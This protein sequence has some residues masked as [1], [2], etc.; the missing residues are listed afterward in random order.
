[1]KV[2]SFGE[3]LWD[4]IGE[5]A[6]LGGAPL[7]FAA[8]S[9]LC[10][11]RSSMLSRLGNDDFGK[12]AGNQIE[13]L[14][15]GTNLLQI[16]QG[17]PTG[18]VPVKLVDGQPDYYITSNAAYDFIDF[19]EAKA[20]LDHEKFEVLYFGTL[21]QRAK[22]GKALKQILSH[23]DFQLKFYDINLRKDCYSE[24]VIRFSLGQAD[25]VKLNEEEVVQIGQMLFGKAL[26]PDNFVPELRM[27]FPQID[28]VILTAGGDGC[29]VF[30]DNTLHHIKSEPVK[31]VDAIGAGDSFSAAFMY[32]FYKSGDILQSARIGNQLGGF[33]A[34]SSG[35][36]PQYSQDIKDLLEAV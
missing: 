2:L 22:S 33:V 7:N 32:S 1:M 31:V 16:D 14:G 6:H 13:K 5:E 20:V 26:P 24:E 8:H 18:T 10:G 15:V 3:V 27:S 12:D 34:S 19:S 28:H 4:I 30:V 35:A 11:G 29:Y 25:I 36:I 17:H 9:V 23:Y 21:V